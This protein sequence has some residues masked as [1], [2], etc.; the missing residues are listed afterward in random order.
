M[1]FIN[2]VKTI[3]PA[4]G[5]PT[6]YITL[7]AQNLPVGAATPF[8]LTG[9]TNF[10]RSGRVRF[11]LTLAPSTAA[12]T[13]VRITCTDGT[14]TNVLYMDTVT[15]TAGDLLDFLY[16][17]VSELNNTTVT[18]TITVAAGGAAGTV[19]LEITGNP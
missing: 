1:A 4:F 6:E 5:T 16:S 8:A 19:D 17:F 12:V 18:V 15:R 14:T 10:V 13:G 3:T 9:F 2:T 11:H 7:L